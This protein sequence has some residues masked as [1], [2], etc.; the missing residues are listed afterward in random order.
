M[1]MVKLKKNKISII[2]VILFFNILSCIGIP[3]LEHYFSNIK[4]IYLI[5]NVISFFM[6]WFKKKN[7][8]AKGFIK[9]VLIY[10]SILILS[11][12]INNG[13]FFQLIYEFTTMLL[14]LILVNSAKKNDINKYLNI[15]FLCLE[16]LTY[17]DLLIIIIYPNGLYHIT[18]S[19]NFYLFNHVNEAIRY[20]LPGVCF[21]MLRSYCNNNKLD[22][23]SYLY[24]I[25][26]GM[27]LLLTWPATGIVGFG[28]YLVVFIL[29]IKKEKIANI[30]SPINSYFVSLF[31]SYLL[32]FK[33]IKNLFFSSVFNFLKRDVT[34]TGRTVLWNNTVYYIKEKLL[35][36][37][38]RQSTEFRKK[39]IGAISS[40]NNF[41]DIVF[42]G[43]LIL[44]MF[45]IFTIIVISKQLKL[46]NNKKIVISLSATIFAYS[47]MW[48][49]LPFSYSGTSLMFMVWMFAYNSSFLFNR[50]EVINSESN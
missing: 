30:F 1:R 36:G 19:R 40:H 32:I 34:L 47:I 13:D 27:T 39:Y 43:G 14:T 45:L 20:L 21:C 17:L 10:Y 42:E 46:C 38:G 48:I 29:L 22:L 11:T 16:V 37:Y 8:S 44:F 7:L 3:C 33:G 15:I 5:I 41:L 23:R 24:F 35:L 50:K 6:L 2:D 26:V 4:Y 31:V 49:T 9:Y 12:I 18:S 28:L 25:V